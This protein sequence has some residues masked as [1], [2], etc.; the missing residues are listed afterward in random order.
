MFVQQLEQPHIVYGVKLVQ[1]DYDP[2]GHVKNTRK[3]ETSKNQPDIAEYFYREQ[4]ILDAKASA[5]SSQR[6]DK[7]KD[8]QMPKPTKRL[9]L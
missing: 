5:R 7:R 9:T 6:G 1:H 2:E 4:A 3:F 8:F